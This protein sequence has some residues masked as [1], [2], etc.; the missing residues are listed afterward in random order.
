MSADRPNWNPKVPTPRAGRMPPK[1]W[2]RLDPKLSEKVRKLLSVVAPATAAAIDRNLRPVYD[3]AVSSWPVRKVGSLNSRGKTALEYTVAGG[4]FKA[5]L[6]NR[7]PYAWFIRGN[8]TAQGLIL[9]P[10]RIAAGKI[11][12]EAA[13]EIALRA[14]RGR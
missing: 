2:I 11:G 1:A 14:A 4:V 10:A 6:Q 13:D 5:T 7:A 9:K 3:R 12:K 8:R